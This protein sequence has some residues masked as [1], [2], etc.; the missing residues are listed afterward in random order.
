MTP[1]IDLKSQLTLTLQ[2]IEA[3]VPFADQA[4]IMTDEDVAYDEWECIVQALYNA[5]IVLPLCDTTGRWS[6]EQFHRLGFELKKSDVV[7]VISYQENV[8][9]LFDLIKSKHGRMHL[10]LRSMSAEAASSNV[11]AL[12]Q[13]C[14]SISVAFLDEEL[15]NGGHSFRLTPL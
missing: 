10:L 8:F 11:R 13:D 7:P 14:E 12:P 9:V 6:P 4:G 5:F 3:V 1:Q 15:P 2:A